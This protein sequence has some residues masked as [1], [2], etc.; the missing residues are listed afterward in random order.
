MRLQQRTCGAPSRSFPTSLFRRLPREAG[1]PPIRQHD[2]MQPQSWGPQMTF[3]WCARPRDLGFGPRSTGVLPSSLRC[4]IVPMPLDRC[5]ICSLESSQ[6]E[7]ICPNCQ[8]LAFWARLA[9]DQR[10]DGGRIGRGFMDAAGKGGFRQVSAPISCS[11]CGRPSSKVRAL[12]SITPPSAICSD[13][14]DECCE[15]LREICRGLREN[16]F[17]W[18]KADDG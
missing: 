3:F 12:L 14:V 9:N 18:S 17:R 16:W 7:P 11:F 4:R 2:H 5:V 15:R 10:A 13:C 6:A 1:L 8:R